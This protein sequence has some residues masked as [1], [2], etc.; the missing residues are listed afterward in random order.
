MLL[1]PGGSREHSLRAC[2]HHLTHTRIWPQIHF[3]GIAG[4]I[5]LVHF[6]VEEDDIISCLPENGQ[7]H[8]LFNKSNQTKLAAKLHLVGVCTSTKVMPLDI[9]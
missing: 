8:V 1:E 6:S 3:S 2:A 9:L 5:N 7:Q 4:R